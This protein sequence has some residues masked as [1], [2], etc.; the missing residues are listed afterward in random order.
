MNE[1]FLFAILLCWGGGA[2]FLIAEVAM[3]W[4]RHYK[5]RTVRSALFET[6]IMIITWPIWFVIAAFCHIYEGIRAI[7]RNEKI[8]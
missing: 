2:V 3:N 5:G 4:R 1:I 6:S 8:L 7:I